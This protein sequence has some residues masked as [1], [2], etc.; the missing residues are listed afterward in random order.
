MTEYAVVLAAM[1][2]ILS[3]VCAFA[4]VAKAYAVRTESLVTSDCP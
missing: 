2:V 3:A 4:Y 1:A